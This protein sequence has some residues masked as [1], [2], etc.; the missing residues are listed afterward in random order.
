M[1]IPKNFAIHELV[2]PDLF[3]KYS[4]TTTLWLAFDQY[5]LMALQ[6]LRER[7]GSIIVNNWKSGGTRKESGL[8]EMTT[9]TGA[10]LSQH[11]FGRAFDILF[12]GNVTPEQVRQEMKS[13]DLFDRDCRQ[14]TDPKYRT[15]DYI[16]CIEWYDNGKPISWFH[17]DTRN[18]RGPNNSIKVVNV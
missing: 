5:A 16:N 18:D 2:G 6:A 10:A 3:N 9:T 17:F 15:F 13:L 4:V 8:R 7:Y 11:K 1:Y 12:M 14:E